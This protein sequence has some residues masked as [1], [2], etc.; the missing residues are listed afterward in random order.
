MADGSTFDDIDIDTITDINELKRYHS[1]LQKQEQ[2]H[3][4]ELDQILENHNKIDQRILSIKELLPNLKL[5]SKEAGHLTDVIVKTSSLAEKVSSKVRELDLAKSRVQEAIKR[6]D[7]ILDLKSCVEGVQSSFQKEEYEQAAAFIH[8]YLSLDERAMREILPVD[9]EE[10]DLNASFTYLHKAQEDL[11]QAVRKKFDEAVVQRKKSEVERFFKLFPLVGLHEEGLLKFSKYLR[12]QIADLSEVNI[13]TALN[14]NTNDNKATVIFAKTLTLLFEEIAKLVEEHQPL[15]DTFYGPGRM[16]A[17]QKE[18]QEECDKQSEYIIDQFLKSRKFDIVC[19]NLRKSHKPSKSSEVKG[20][21]DPKDLDILL[22][23]IVLLSSRTELYQNFLRK[24]VE[25]DINSL[26]EDE[27][28]KDLE[29][30]CEMLI[31]NSGLSRKLQT[32]MGDY[33]VMEGYFMKEMMA[34]AVSMD[35]SDSDSLTSSMVDDVFFVLQKSLRRTLSTSNINII[36]AVL[37][38]ASSIAMTEYKD[39]LKAKLKATGFPSSTIDLSGMFQGKLQLQTNIS[40]LLEAKKNFLI[41]LNNIDTSGEYLQKLVDDIK[42]ECNRTFKTDG[43]EREKL[44]SCLLDLGAC[45]HS[46]KEILQTGITQLSTNTILPKLNPI[47]DGYSSIKHDLSEEDFS[48]YEVNDPFV[49]N[50]IAT[51]D[52][53][54]NA[55]KKW[56]T[57]SNYESAIGIT[58]HELSVRLEKA[59]MKTTFNRLGGLQFDKELRS[60]IQ[61]LTS[62]TEWTVRDKFARLS[63]IAT[64]LNLEKVSEL[65]EYWGENSGPLTWRLTPG[66]VRNVLSL[67]NDFRKEDIQRL[68]L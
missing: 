38:N 23:E 35:S 65:L 4:A 44:E 22:G 25:N 59:V 20:K 32:L 67:R 56:L 12:Q 21:L 43:S 47:T 49:Q 6:V 30:T 18:L 45:G 50:L 26:P 41:V 15:V 19:E 8:R 37:N 68:K 64:I 55:A 33:I 46:F 42:I 24:T 11:Q 51:L 27:V 17:V 9:T 29:K 40:E 62:I 13:D 5:L 66:E 7:D 34:K 58:C 28:K 16:V 53:S 60:L 3:D 63:Q 52:G 14:I 10:T 2:E 31:S 61:Y 54:L 48:Y 36:C 1:L 57:H 39:M